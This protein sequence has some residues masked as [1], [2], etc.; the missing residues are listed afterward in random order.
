[1]ERRLLEKK[2]QYD[3]MIILSKQQVEEK[4]AKK[5]TTGVDASSKDKFKS[6]LPLGEGV[7]IMDEVEVHVCKCL[8]L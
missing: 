8:I 5:G 1:M 2:K 7:L 3:S 4:R 6:L